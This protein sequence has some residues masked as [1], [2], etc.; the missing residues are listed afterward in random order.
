MTSSMKALSEAV[1]AGRSPGGRLRAA[2]RA[3]VVGLIEQALR[4]GAT[5]VAI[6]E[7]LGVSEQTVAR[8]RTQSADTELAPVRVVGALSPSRS[9]MV[10]GPGGVRIEGLS[11][12]EVAALLGRLS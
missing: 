10:H 12:D 3:E 9:V 1:A 5:Y 11:L 8:W 6:A 4:E 2:A 7:M